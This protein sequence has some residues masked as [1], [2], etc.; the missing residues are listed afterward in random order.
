MTRNK[1]VG[2][3]TKS[4]ENQKLLFATYTYNKIHVTMLLPGKTTA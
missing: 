3:N 2:L 1:Q 4:Q